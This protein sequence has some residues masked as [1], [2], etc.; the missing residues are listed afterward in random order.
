ME[1]QLAALMA[2]LDK[3]TGEVRSNSMCLRC[4]ELQGEVDRLSTQNQSLV[5]EISNIKEYFFAKRNE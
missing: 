3:P 5:N 4:R 1:T 2:N